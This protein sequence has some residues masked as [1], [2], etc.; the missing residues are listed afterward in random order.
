MRGTGKGELSP[1]N[2]R[3]EGLS[4]GNCPEGSCPVP[5]LYCISTDE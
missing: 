3:G 1:V 4:V 2:C 5:E